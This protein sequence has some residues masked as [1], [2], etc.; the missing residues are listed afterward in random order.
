M[1]DTR[2][3]SPEFISFCEEWYD[4]IH[5]LASKIVAMGEDHAPMILVKRGPSTVPALV[6]LTDQ[7]SKVRAMR[8]QIELSQ[9]TQTCFIVEAWVATGKIDDGGA[10]ERSVRAHRGVRNMPGRRE[11]ITFSF[12]HHG[13]Q[14]A[15]VCFI[16]RA[17]KSLEKDKLIDPV[18]SG[19]TGMFMLNRNETRMQ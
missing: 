6:P 13:M 7:A 17:K 19:S 9:F 2:R 15:S 12:M 16:D 11:A 5:K 1:T 18:V 4:D 14:L 3:A 8:A 10:L